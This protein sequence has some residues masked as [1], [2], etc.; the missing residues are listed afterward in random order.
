M[1]SDRV[2]SPSSTTPTSCRVTSTARPCSQV[3]WFL[4]GSTL[5]HH[6]NERK[7]QYHYPQG[8]LRVSACQRDNATYNLTSFFLSRLLLTSWKWAAPSR[9]KHRNVSAVKKI[10]GMTSICR[11]IKEE[12]LHVK[13]VRA[14]VQKK[15]FPSA[16]TETSGKLINNTKVTVRETV[17]KP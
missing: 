8:N 6:S 13:N 14:V 11:Q 9:P 1:P 16:G 2:S 7:V 17:S 10:Q 15:N 4:I 5:N 3:C 12:Y